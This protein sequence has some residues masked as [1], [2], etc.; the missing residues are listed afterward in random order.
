MKAL[1]LT[2]RII[3]AFPFA[4]FGIQ[5]FAFAPSMGA[6]VPDY[7]PA[8]VLLVYISGAV[9]IIT[10]IC[11]MARAYLFQASLLLAALLLVFVIFI[12]VPNMM[13]K[14][15]SMKAMAMSDFF[16]DLSLMGAALYVAVINRGKSKF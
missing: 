15:M 9:F 10:A 13:A 6:L 4:L 8:P 5:H 16:K 14:D 12:H 1:K 2:G 7:F 3:F 11:I